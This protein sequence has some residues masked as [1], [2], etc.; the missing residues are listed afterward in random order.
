MS[1]LYQFAKH[2]IEP[3][4]PIKDHTKSPLL[5][6][7]NLVFP[8]DDKKE[9]K[10]L[11]IRLSILFVNLCVLKQLITLLILNIYNC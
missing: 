1:F 7:M 8:S 2:L 6:L 9:R 11:I 4:P 3:S 5:P 10:V